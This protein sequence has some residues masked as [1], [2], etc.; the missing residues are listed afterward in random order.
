MSPTPT[1][2]TT[3]TTIGEVSWGRFE[4]TVCAACNQVSG[5]DNRC[6]CDT[7][8]VPPLDSEELPS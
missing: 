3:V 2:K 4:V 7:L 6:A 1:P 8:S 5:P